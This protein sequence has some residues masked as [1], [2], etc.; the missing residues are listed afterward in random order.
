M[1]RLERGQITSEYATLDGAPI[2]PRC[3]DEVNVN[4]GLF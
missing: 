1:L 4:D 2:L 3:L